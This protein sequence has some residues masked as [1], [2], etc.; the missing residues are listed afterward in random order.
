[1]YES[2]LDVFRFTSCSG[3]ILCWLPFAVTGN[4]INDSD[5]TQNLIKFYKF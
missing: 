2:L 4:D 1:M 5:N 3:C